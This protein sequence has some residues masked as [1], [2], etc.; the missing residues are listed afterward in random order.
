M[1][2]AYPTSFPLPPL[3]SVLGV[4]LV[5]KV[6]NLGPIRYPVHILGLQASVEGADF[7]LGAPNSS[8]P[9][10]KSTP[11]PASQRLGCTRTRQVQTRLHGPSS[12]AAEPITERPGSVT[13][14]HNARGGRQGHLHTRDP[15]TPVQRALRGSLHPERPAWVSQKLR[16]EWPG[17]GTWTLGWEGAGPDDHSLPRLDSRSLVRSPK[18][19]HSL[20][21]CKT[22]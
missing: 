10:L 22:T 5:P 8:P 14:P 18:A 21:V 13:H 20:T 1:E 17:P 11:S 12:P 16:G 9:E 15:P 3:P 4:S 6:C 7:P 19:A 2:P